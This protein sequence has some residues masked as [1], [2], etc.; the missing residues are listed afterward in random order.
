MHST[1]TVLF[2]MSAPFQINYYT[3][4]AIME[5]KR[6][7][8]FTY[9]EQFTKTNFSFGNENFD[10]GSTY[11]SDFSPGVARSGMAQLPSIAATKSMSKSIVT[12]PCDVIAMTS[13]TSEPPQ[14]CERMQ[15]EKH[16]SNHSIDSERQNRI[17]KLQ[18]EPKKTL[19]GTNI[20]FGNDVTSD[21]RTAYQ[22]FAA[23]PPV[24]FPRRRPISPPIVAEVGIE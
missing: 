1:V 20:S 12:L 7:N 18:A 11:L 19:R 24:D 22:E 15:I 6:R 10:C 13:R 16:Q 5:S 2:Y 4:F 21:V 17:A 3:Y 14:S 23:L 8:R 9:S